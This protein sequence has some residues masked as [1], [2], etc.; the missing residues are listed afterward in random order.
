MANIESCVLLR[1]CMVIGTT[2]QYQYVFA[3]SIGLWR[4]FQCSAVIAAPPAFRGRVGSEH[5][6]RDGLLEAGP[7]AAGLAG[8]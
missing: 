3:H 2:V 6:V 4:L 1:N 5:S 8:G 7:G